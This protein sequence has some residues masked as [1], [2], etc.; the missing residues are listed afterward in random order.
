VAGEREGGP[1]VYVIDPH[2]YSVFMDVPLAFEPAA[3]VMD[4]QPER[5]SVDR[6][7]ILA[8]AV[9]GSVASVDVGGNAFGYRMP[10]VLMGAL[11]AAGIYLLA[12]LL[13][14]RRSVALFA[15][16]L[17]LA[18]GMLFANPRIAMNDAY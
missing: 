12:R 6:T 13:F 7:Q 4:T 10:G 18:E 5:P 17:A 8:L 15:A 9:D 11:T 14:R 3:L 16:A 2:G 1:T